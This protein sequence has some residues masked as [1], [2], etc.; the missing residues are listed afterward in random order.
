[1]G[2]EILRIA[3]RA[4]LASTRQADLTAR[5]GG[6]EFAAILPG[7][8]LATARL[9]AERIRRAIMDSV[10]VS[11]GTVVF[12]HGDTVASLMERADRCLY[13][14]KRRGRNR[15]ICEGDLA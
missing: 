6:D 15:V 5:I 14:A 13:E 1:M 9:T 3:A 4:L 2:D 12:R 11:I 8:D 7:A 10:T